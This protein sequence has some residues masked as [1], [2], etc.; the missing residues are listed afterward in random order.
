MPEMSRHKQVWVKVNAQV[1]EELAELVVALNAVPELETVESCQGGPIEG[2]SG[3]ANAFIYF[4]YGD[5]PQISRFAFDE[6]APALSRIGSV[7]VDRAG[8]GNPMGK[9]II[10]PGCL[11]QATDRLLQVLSRHE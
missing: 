2:R 5:W 9:I 6:M 8:T 7:Q 10:L 3:V 1:D 11:D 4:Y